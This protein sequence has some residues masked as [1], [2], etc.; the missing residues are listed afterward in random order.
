MAE[1]VVNK[2][3]IKDE[4]SHTLPVTIEEAGECASDFYLINLVGKL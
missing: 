3:V 1:Y 2:D 4:K